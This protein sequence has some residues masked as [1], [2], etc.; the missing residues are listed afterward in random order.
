M[1]SAHD[2]CRIC[3]E[4]GEL[5]DIGCACKDGL[6]YAHSECAQK[7]FEQRIDVTWRGKLNSKTWT[8]VLDCVCEVCHSEI[9]FRIKEAVFN[10]YAA[11]CSHKCTIQPEMQC[12]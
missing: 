10:K 6:Q 2:Q 4:P 7:W 8:V 1:D 11:N 12:S 5:I 9:A 3:M